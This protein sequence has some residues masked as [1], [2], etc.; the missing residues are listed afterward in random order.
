MDHIVPRRAM[1]RGRPEQP[2]QAVLAFTSSI[3]N[4]VG[5]KNVIPGRVE[6][7]NYDAR[8][9]SENLEIPGLVLRTIPE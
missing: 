3:I 9:T 7:A 6:D 4:I 1:H 5:N 8:C 2:L